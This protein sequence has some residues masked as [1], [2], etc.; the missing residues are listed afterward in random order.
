M[1][2]VEYVTY[3]DCRPLCRT[4]YDTQHDFAACPRTRSGPVKFSTQHRDYPVGFVT[5]PADSL[6]PPRCRPLLRVDSS[7]AFFYKFGWLYE[8]HFGTC[9]LIHRN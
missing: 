3:A 9:S 4:C 8:K 1:T 6:R 5:V 2:R 7:A